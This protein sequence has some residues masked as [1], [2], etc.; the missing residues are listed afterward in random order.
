VIPDAEHAICELKWH[1]EIMQSW[2]FAISSAIDTSPVVN[3]SQLGWSDPTSIDG[4]QHSSRQLYEHV[5]ARHV[6]TVASVICMATPLPGIGGL[7]DLPKERRLV[8]TARCATL[9]RVNPSP[10][11]NSPPVTA[12]SRAQGASGCDGGA[13]MPALGSRR[14]IVAVLVI[15]LGLIATGCAGTTT[16]TTPPQGTPAAPPSAETTQAAESG[17]TV[18]TTEGPYYVTGTTELS[19]GNLNAAKLPGDPI[20]VSGVV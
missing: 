12:Y 19:D 14:V 6:I 3:V 13:A 4:A 18:G 11:R 10:P 5:S 1:S 15:G 8:I 7:Y 20:K 17:L 9:A 16:P 2:T